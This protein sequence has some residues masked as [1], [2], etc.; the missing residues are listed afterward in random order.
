MM[1][2][3]KQY[4]E[5]FDLLSND[6]RK[7]RQTRGMP[8]AAKIEKTLIDASNGV[9]EST[10]NLSDVFHLYTRDLDFPKLNIQQQMLLM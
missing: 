5:V 4:F 3:R 8:L 10:D 7:F 6:L 9:A 1:Y 2:C